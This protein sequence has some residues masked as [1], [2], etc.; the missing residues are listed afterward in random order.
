M[1]KVYILRAVKIIAL[2]LLFAFTVHISQLYAFQHNGYNKNRIAGFYLEDKNSLDVAF[3]GA[4]EVFADFSSAYAYEKFGFTSYPYSTDYNLVSLYKYQL[5]EILKH[6]NPKLIVVELTMTVNENNDDFSDESNIRNIEA[7]MPLSVNKAESVFKNVDN[8]YLSYLFP[9]IKYHDTWKDLGTLKQYIKDSYAMRSRGYTLLKG[10]TTKPHIAKL[11]NLIDVTN[12]NTV[13]KL[14]DTMLCKRYLTEFLDYCKEK[15]LDNVLFVMYPHAVIDS[16]YN[17]FCRA[18]AAGKLVE[19]Y[20]YEF[21]NLEHKANEIGLD[22]QKDF[23]NYDHLN[24]YGQQKFT[25]YFGNML[26]NKYG[27]NN[28]GMSEKLK[29]EWD[30]S[31]EYINKFYNYVDNYIENNPDSDA[32][33]YETSDLI[34]KLRNDY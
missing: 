8:D 12:D 13:A 27:I 26:K 19:S 32:L 34:E 4:S 15:E 18:N 33:F 5:E 14:D 29:N 16:T 23:Y 17:R 25:E 30:N 10:A 22:Y 11:E 2:V 7:L 1:K 31:A 20:G 21:L 28:E 6:Q 9:I 24:V 3:L